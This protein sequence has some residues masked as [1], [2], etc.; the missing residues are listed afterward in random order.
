MIGITQKTIWLRTKVDC[1]MQCLGMKTSTDRQ[2]AES[3]KYRQP[4]TVA[5]NPGQRESILAQ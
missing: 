5:H 2:L 3:M 4:K 1:R